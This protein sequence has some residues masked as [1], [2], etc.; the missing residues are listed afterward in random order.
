M[1]LRNAVTRSM[2]QWGYGKGYEHAHKFED[3]IPGMECLPDALA[4]REFYQ[5]TNR[6]VEQ[7]IADRLAEIRARK[8]ERRGKDEPDAG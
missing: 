6:G 5:P 7:R 1:Q 4:G 3:A 8:A 2:K